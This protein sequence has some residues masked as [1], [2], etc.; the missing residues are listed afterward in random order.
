MKLRAGELRE[1]ITFVS[2]T[3]AID[4][5]LGG[6]TGATTD[7]KTV[8]AKRAPEGAFQRTEASAAN[9]VGRKTFWI[10]WTTGLTPAMWVRHDSVMH[11]IVGTEVIE[12]R[13]VLAVH[14]EVRD[15]QPA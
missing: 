8:P 3:G 5:V 2:P 10:R 7:I 13:E 4:P 12:H 9:S 6:E 14:C 1:R 15:E 11:T